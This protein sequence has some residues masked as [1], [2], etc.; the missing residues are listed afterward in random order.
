[1]SIICNVLDKSTGRAQSAKI[2]ALLMLGVLNDN[3]IQF[4]DTHLTKILVNILM[5]DDSVEVLEMCLEV[6]RGQAENGN[7]MR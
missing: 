3:N 2:K 4:L 5:T 7:I 6:L 1:M